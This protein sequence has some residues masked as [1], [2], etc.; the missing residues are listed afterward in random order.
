M[1][2]NLKPTWIFIQRHDTSRVMWRCL[3][4]G[5]IQACSIQE[6]ESIKAITGNVKR[7]HETHT[8]SC[9]QIPHVPSTKQK[10]K[11]DNNQALCRPTLTPNFP[12]QT[13]QFGLMDDIPFIDPT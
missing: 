2:I 8:P 5:K 11:F 1:I 10:N 12:W 4:C 9:Y 6:L 3:E 13:T 7:S